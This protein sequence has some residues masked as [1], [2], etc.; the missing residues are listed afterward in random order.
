M[1]STDTPEGLVF[2]YCQLQFLP[3]RVYLLYFSW[4][5]FSSD[6]GRLRAPGLLREVLREERRKSLLLFKCH[7]LGLPLF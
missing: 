2:F 1:C 5:R 7:V 6:Q 3:S 4:R